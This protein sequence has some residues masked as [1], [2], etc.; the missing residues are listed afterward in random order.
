MLPTKYNAI[1]LLYF[2]FISNLFLQHDKT[3]DIIFITSGQVTK[4]KTLNW[5]ASITLYIGI[6]YIADNPIEEYV[7]I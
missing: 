4:K 7:T 6:R 1:L 3:L 2:F 5:V